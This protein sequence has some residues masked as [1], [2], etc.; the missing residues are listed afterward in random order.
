[1]KESQKRKNIIAVCCATLRELSVLEPMDAICKRANELGFGVQIFQA[2]EEIAGNQDVYEGEESAFRLI[3]YDEI[4]GLIIF[5]ERI[6][7]QEIISGL[8]K[9]AK[10]HDIPA[11]SFD[12]KEEGCINV[13]FDY[14]DA[15]EQIVRH[16]VEHHKFKDFFIMAGMKDNSFTDERLDVI[17]K[18]FSENNIELRGEDIAYGEFWDWP[19]RA[20]MNE[21]FES[22]RNMPE[23][24]IAMNDTMATIVI[25]ELQKH[26]YK[27]PEDT[28]VTGFDGIYLSEYFVPKVT[29]AKQQF[30]VAGEKAVEAILECLSGKCENT[31]DISIPFKMLA[32]QSC[33]CHGVDISR[34]AANV[35][36]LYSNFESSKRFSGFMEEMS[37]RMIVNIGIDRFRYES[38]GYS[39]FLDNHDR[40]LLCIYK[41]FLKVDDKAYINLCSQYP[42]LAIDDENDMV[43]VVDGGKATDH[44]FEMQ[45]FVEADILPDMYSYI[46]EA[47]NII[48]VPIHT[49]S[50]IYGH[51]VLNYKIGNRD[52]YKTKTYINKVS[53]MLFLI[54]QQNKL[55][56]SNRELMVMK[57]QLEEM[58]ITDPMTGIFNR[59]GFYQ[60]YE[61]LKQIKT[62]GT[63]TLISI[64]LDNLKKIN[65]TYGHQE[66]DY[67]IKSLSDALSEIVGS[68]GL[69]ARFGGDEFVA[70]IFDIDK[71]DNITDVLYEDITNRLIRYEKE[72]NKPY[73]LRCSLG[74]IQ[75]DWSNSSDMETLINSSDKLLYNMKKLHHEGA[76]D[77]R[78]RKC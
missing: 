32:R 21:F 12:R 77:R 48:I 60:K 20:A 78:Q 10:A 64:D 57:N 17:R 16:L 52:A 65:D 1:M 33:G 23:A 37:R 18:V 71:V 70:L 69:Y 7:N 68:N 36:D 5:S 35:S 50:E 73:E 3:N 28:V 61:E 26:G 51:A 58:Y 13:T 39:H 43:V 59:R 15:F 40:V 55:S 19:T 75:T 30:D 67:A 38:N 56:N 4:S 72:G 41:E 24:F 42:D 29:T 34:I 22:G 76:N 2:F 74:A 11:V 54:E 49:G 31:L 66:G 63:A 25:D 6:K 8:I 47:K 53:N 14:A 27:V 46:S 44:S 9:Q 45:T 62:D